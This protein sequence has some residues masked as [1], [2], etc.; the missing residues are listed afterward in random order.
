MASAGRILLIP[1]GRYDS[2]A[3]YQML[4]VVLHNGVSWV[5]KGEVTG[6]EP[7]DTAEEWQKF[8]E[9]IYKYVIGNADISNIG[10]GT[11][12]GAIRA[13]NDAVDNKVDKNGTAA[14]KSVEL[15]KAE[16]GK[17]SIYKNHDETKDNGLTIVD[18]DASGKYVGLI[19]SGSEQT[20]KINFNGNQHDI[21]TKADFTV[22]GTDLIL[23]WL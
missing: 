20:A 23:N 19:L 16:N 10:D 12:K 6:V 1:R 7:S 9:D 14:F 2:K 8:T 3:T 15:Q 17:G 22:S 5:C 11:V 4:D 18:T 13:M 21:L